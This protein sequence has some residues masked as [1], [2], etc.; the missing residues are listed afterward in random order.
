[1]N[2]YRIGE[3]A[4][5]LETSVDTLRYYERIG[6]LP[7]V[8]RAESGVRR[9]DDEDISRL[10]FIRRAQLMNFSLGEISELLEVRKNPRRSK[11]KARALAAAKLEEIDMRLETLKK[12]RKELGEMVKAC[13]GSAN[14]CAIISGIEWQSRP[15]RRTKRTVRG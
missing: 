9:F 6:L 3:A 1:M 15:V 2:Q 12:L 14:G 13:P 5:M 8:A 11:K 10:R 4:R 7:S